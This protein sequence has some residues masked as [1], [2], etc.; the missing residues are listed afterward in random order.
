MKAYQVT[1]F[2]TGEISRMFA[3]RIDLPQYRSGC[4]YMINYFPHQTGPAVKRPGTMYGG[5]AA[6]K[7]ILVPWIKSETEY[8]VLEITASKIRYYSYDEDTQKL[9]LIEDAGS[10]VETDLTAASWATSDELLK[11]KYVQTSVTILHDT[12]YFTCPGHTL[13]KLVRTSDT[14]WAF[15]AASLTDYGGTNA[16]AC[17][18]YA[19]RLILSESPSV[20]TIYGSKTGSFLDFGVSSPVEAA[21]GFEITIE[22]KE[23]TNILWLAAGDELMFGTPSYVFLVVGKSEVL[24]ADEIYSIAPTPQSSVGCANIQPVRYNE[25]LVFVQKGGKKLHMIVYDKEDELYSTNDI[26]FFADHITGNGLKQIFMKRNYEPILFGITEGGKLVSMVYSNVT[27]S[28]GWSQH[29]LNGTVEAGCVIQTSGEDVVCLSVLRGSDRHIETITKLD[30]GNI[31]DAHYVDAGVVWDGGAA[32]DITGI[33]A[34]DEGAETASVVTAA[35]HGFSDDELVRIL[36]VEEDDDINGEVYTVK[37]S[38]TDNF[39]LYS[40]DGTN[41]VYV[42]TA[43]ATGTVRKVTNTVSGIDHLDGKEVAGIGDGSVLAEV[44]V[45]SGEA[46]FEEYS[47]KI[48]AGLA[49]TGVVQP[50]TIADSIHK[51]KTIKKIYAKFLDGTVFKYGEDL[52]NLTTETLEEG[53]P[54]M[55]VASGVELSDLNTYFEGDRSTDPEFMIVSDSPLPLTILNIVAEVE[56]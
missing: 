20:A 48:H 13:R 16:E 26:T 45:D 38:T 14:S 6:G 21:D 52:D 33:T 15:S 11:I 34:G 55:G 37:N 41:K 17:E 25:Y 53:A 49:Y 54:I 10:P 12:M 39:D 28:I 47:N 8:L 56:T 29:D 43:C 40:L 51:L 2:T 4:K 36:D 42:G 9:S 3:G 7:C 44:T 50:N 35:S 24:Y 32:V 1:S 30:Y 22:A 31:E 5:T 46:V 18:I 27:K 23:N 19:T